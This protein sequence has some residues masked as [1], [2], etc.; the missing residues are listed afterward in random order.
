MLGELTAL[1]MQHGGVIVKQVREAL[2]ARAQGTLFGPEQIA[3]WTKE[4]DA[5]F[6]DGQASLPSPASRSPR[7]QLGKCQPEAM[8]DAGWQQ[9]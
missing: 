9:R 7:S 1:L 2:A 4:S 6:A 5:L 8:R 3:K